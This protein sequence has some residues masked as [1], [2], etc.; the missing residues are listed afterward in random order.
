M[1]FPV[2]SPI[3]ITFSLEV[4]PDG[5]FVGVLKVFIRFPSGSVTNIFASERSSIQNMDPSKQKPSMEKDGDL[6]EVIT[7]PESGS[8]VTIEFVN[9]SAV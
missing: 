7:E 2:R 1:I 6:K 5:V 3:Q 4:S 8:M 9:L